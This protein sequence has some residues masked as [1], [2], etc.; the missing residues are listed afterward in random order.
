MVVLEDLTN[1][2]SVLTGEIAALDNKKSILQGEIR[3]SASSV[4]GEIKAMGENAVS[5][6]E[7]QTDQIKT[8]IDSL[9]AEALR[10]TVIVDEMK[11]AARKGEE[12]EKSLG[13]FIGEINGK[14]GTN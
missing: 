7:Q 9:V 12:S 2:K 8:K 5:E 6:L 1:Q 3:Q 10:L 11:A 13:H 4:V 14:V